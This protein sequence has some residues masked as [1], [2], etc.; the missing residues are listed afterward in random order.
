MCRLSYADICRRRRCCYYFVFVHVLVI[1]V[2]LSRSLS[3]SLS[4]LF[5][6]I[7]FWSKKKKRKIIKAR[8]DS[9]SRT[10]DGFVEGKCLLG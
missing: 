9:Y 1:F 10:F 7:F 5:R 8:Y 6:P 3:R 4:L 2:S